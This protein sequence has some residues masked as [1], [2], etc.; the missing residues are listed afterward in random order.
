MPRLRFIPLVAVFLLPTTVLAADWPH[1]L[2]PN[3]NGSSPEK[4]LMTKFPAKGPKV[5]WK[6]PGGEGYSSIAVA[7][8]RAIT[9]VQRGKEELALAL[10]PATGKELWTAKIGPSYK[11]GFGNGP[12]STPTIEGDFVYVT[13]VTGPVVCLKADT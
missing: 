2:G 5:L 11:N 13:S 3:S 10:D 7:G 8:G 6:V 12:R 9:L 1:W 4:G